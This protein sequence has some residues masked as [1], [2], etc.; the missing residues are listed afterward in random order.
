MKDILPSVSCQGLE[1][2]KRLFAKLGLNTIRIFFISFL[3]TTDWSER[4][5]LQEALDGQWL[6]VEATVAEASVQR[7][8]RLTIVRARLEQEGCCCRDLV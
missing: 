5:S 2:K 6:T 3:V 7:K 8:G 1:L 4:H